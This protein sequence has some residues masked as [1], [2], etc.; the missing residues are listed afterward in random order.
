MRKFYEAQVDKIRAQLH[1]ATQAQRDS[2]RARDDE[3]SQWKQRESELEAAAAAHRDDV[4]RLERENQQLRE[5]LE[6]ERMHLTELEISDVLAEQLARQPE[7]ERSVKESVQLHVHR[8]VR[9][10]QRELEAA[11]QETASLQQLCDSYEKRV[12]VSNDDA[13]K[14]VRALEAAERRLQ[15]DLE[16]SEATRTELEQQIATLVTQLEC[17][18]AREKEIEQERAALRPA[19]AMQD[20]VETLKT[21]N[22]RLQERC[23]AAEQT[24]ESANREREELQQ[25]VTLLEADKTFLV[26][27]KRQLE[28][29]EARL[30]SKQKELQSRLDLLQATHVS[31]TREMHRVHDESRLQFEKQLETELQRFMEMSKREIETIR[32]SSQMT[33]ER[34]NRLLREARDDAL[35]QIDSLQSRLQ[36]VQTTLE[37]NTLELTRRENAHTTTVA[38]LRNDLKMKHFELSQLGASLDERMTELHSA[39]RQIE[40]LEQKVRVLQEEFARLE[41]TSTTRIAQLEAE[42]DMERNKLRQYEQLEV[43]LDDA[44]LQTGALSAAD[45]NDDGQP[46]MHDVMNTFAAIPTT[47]KRR[48]QQSVLLAQRVVKHQKEAMELQRQVA[49][50]TQEKTHLEREV[51]ELRHR[52]ANLHQPQAYLIDKLTR[53]DQEIQTLRQQ[54]AQLE[55]QLQDLRNELRETTLARIALQGQLQHVLARREELQTLKSSVQALRKRVQVS[56]T[57]SAK[58]N[59]AP[60]LA[61]VPGLMTLKTPPSPDVLSQMT[62]PPTTPSS[63]KERTACSSSSPI[64]NKPTDGG[65]SSPAV[66]EGSNGHPNWYIKLRS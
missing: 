47:T 48:F 55:T 17:L 66:S 8:L 39:K 10:M 15:L 32:S 33:Y 61:T 19:K 36:A 42:L 9:A 54:Q 7:R 60:S 63:D 22:G 37:E 25:K 51:S 6:I 58:Q 27:V 65:N 52:L 46:A 14:R 41:T 16:L 59:T 49:M 3:R 11:R 28:E 45:A 21:E 38:T 5:R 53:K 62:R 64:E 34:E 31:E 35:K 30:L 20:E 1:T 13:M 43:D 50:V 29:Q 40:L 24:I 4:A 44:V 2:E 56:A 12:E 26:D 57:A 23:L 18:Q